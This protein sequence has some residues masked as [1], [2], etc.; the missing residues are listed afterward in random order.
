MG[1]K[2]TDL[3]T[4]KRTLTSE[5]HE[6]CRLIAE[7]GLGTVLSARQAYGWK[8]AKPGDKDYIKA[9]NKR[10]F[11]HIKYEIA[12]LRE[13][14]QKEADAEALISQ[15]GGN[16]D[17]DAM[18]RFAYMRLQSLR[19]SPDAP[20]SAKFKAV[21]ALEKLHDP[22]QD[23]NLIWTYIDL[24]TS[25]LDAH[26]PACHT[27]FPLASV[28]MPGLVTYR[29]EHDLDTPEP[30]TDLYDRR[31]ILIKKAEKRARPHVGQVLALGTLERHIVGLGAARAGKSFLLSLFAYLYFLQPGSECWLLAR[32]YEDARSEKEYL[33]AFMK[34]AFAPVGKHM[35]TEHYDNK[36]GEWTL[37][38]RWGSEVKIKSATA[39]GS[40]TARELDACL[41]AEPGWV[42]DDIYNQVVARLVSRLGRII[43][44]GTPQGMGGF[45]SRL[46]FTTGRD[47]KTG[48]VR[49]LTKE[50]RLL[51]NGADWNISALVFNLSPEQNPAYVKSELAAARQ[52]MG[53]EE[54]E[55][56]FEG[57]MVAY[58]GMKFYEI[59]QRHLQTLRQADMADC[60]F[61]LGIDQGP[62]NFGGVLLA[63]DGTRIFI[64]KE[65]FES[66]F[67]T[68]R[69]NMATLMNDTP[70]WIRAMGG[71]PGEWRSTIFDQDP[72]VH[73]T[74]QEMESEGKTWPTDIT[75]RHDNKK[76]GGLTE[77]WRKDT[78]IYINDMAKRGNIIFCDEEGPQ[79][80][81][82]CMRVENIPPNPSTDGGGG[83][84]KGWKIAGS[85]RK[86]HV[87]DAFMLAMWVI[88]S[89]QVEMPDS[90]PV[91]HDAH[92]EEMR[93]WRTRL[94][95]DEERELM[96]FVDQKHTSTDQIFE[97]EFGRKRDNSDVIGTTRGYYHDY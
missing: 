76:T 43:A 64:V 48:K 88:L 93:G 39:K 84:N 57:K 60:V 36:S 59:K 96:G 4:K 33:Q 19:D 70:I 7:E 16:I 29:Q 52:V 78:T 66:S 14:A 58:E 72:P 87:L 97:E 81:D 20:P 49:R 1:G 21:E 18:I 9:K 68:I 8:C 35:V 45:I 50:D 55:T 79:L 37:T 74:L 67:A 12:R 40:I 30:V 46:V 25:G 53:D 44:L 38:S 86:D 3:R 26:C 24:A 51:K 65:Y 90:P 5:D 77:D 11:A 23:V 91:D 42:P 92:A 61:I 34:T 73:N 28:Q 80:H 31:N 2:K 63:Y 95:M 13:A 71:I 6:F 56:E 75:F 82:E 69:A 47:P 85:W 27:E 10:K 17:E 83:K 54:Y 15:A 94:K 32:T 22:S 62:K 41:V 89:K